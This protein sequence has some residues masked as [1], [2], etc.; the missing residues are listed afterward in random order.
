MIHRILAISLKDIVAL[1]DGRPLVSSAIALS[2][3]AVAAPTPL[4]ARNFTRLLLL[5]GATL[6]MI[7]A[8]HQV[9]APSLPAAVP[10]TAVERA[11]SK[12]LQEP[13]KVSIFAQEQAM[14]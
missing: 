1:S 2:T 14:S 12:A 10:E 3:R 11:V 13:E 9:R 6:A 7:V 8:L 5:G 4:P